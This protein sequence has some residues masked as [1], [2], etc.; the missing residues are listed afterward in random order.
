MNQT[1]LIIGGSSDIARTLTSSLAASGANLII[2]ARDTERIKLSGQN[3]EIIKGD[4]L[5]SNKVEEALEKSLEKGGGKIDGVTNLVGSILIKPPH[6]MT[7]DDFRE[8]IETN[9]TSA[10]LTLSLSCKKIVKNGGGRLVFTSS[11]AG[12]LGLPNHEAISAAK[13]G[14]ESMVRSAAS[15]YA[16]KGIRINAVA[17]GLTETRLTAGILSSEPIKKMATEMIPTRK[18]SQQEQIASS[19]EWLLT[20]APDNFTGQVLNLDGGMSS[21][22]A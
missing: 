19:I 2:L 21:I 1:F 7:L 17:P 15:T 8:V 12:S 10:F 20:D 4:A 3:I 9:L 18:I 11:V 13:G 6:L 22:R 16:R 5:D 14:I